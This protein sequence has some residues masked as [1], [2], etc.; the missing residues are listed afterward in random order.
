M[1]HYR[2]TRRKTETGHRYEVR[3]AYV[4]DEGNVTGIGGRLSDLY[5]T[6]WEEAAVEAES[7]CGA[8]DLPVYDL[9]GN[10]EVGRDEE[11]FPNDAHDR[12]RTLDA[13]LMQYRY[14]LLGTVDGIRDTIQK[15]RSVYPG[16][17]VTGLA[18]T[19]TLLT[20]VADDLAKLLDGE[21]LRKWRIEGTLSEPVA[22]EGNPCP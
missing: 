6:T 15:V 21:G 20:H 13:R 22:G 18:D 11:P 12:A 10:A 19:A 7:V 4:D 1:S 9:D 2:I 5:G 17:D 3:E 14:G 8:T 16:K